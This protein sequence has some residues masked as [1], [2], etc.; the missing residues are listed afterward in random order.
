METKR[1]VILADDE[2]HI[3]AMMKAVISSMNC[4]IVGEAADG[5]EAVDLYKKEK[6]DLLLLDINMS[7]KSGID[8]LREIMREFPAATVIMLTSVVDMEDVKQCIDLGA[9]NY[10]RKDTSVTEMRQVIK[11]TLERLP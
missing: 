6:P 5:Q 10:I 11:D 9:A 2:K 1:R 8:G 4:E 3:R 7:Q